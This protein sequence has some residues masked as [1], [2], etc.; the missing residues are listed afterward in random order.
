[1]DG[2]L[3]GQ[4]QGCQPGFPVRVYPWL[5]SEGER[6]KNG[7]MELHLRGNDVCYTEGLETLYGGRKGGQNGR[8]EV[9]GGRQ[10]LNYIRKL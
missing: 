6:I 9:I 5:S 4:R 8:G 3:G 2:V 10:E 1:M 7:E